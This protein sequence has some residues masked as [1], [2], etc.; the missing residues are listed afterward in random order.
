MTFEDWYE[1]YPFK[2]TSISSNHKDILKDAWNAAI[3]AALDK[4][5]YEE[6]YYDNGNKWNDDCYSSTDPKSDIKKLLTA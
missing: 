6:Y 5:Y 2:V 4:L 3:S 1:C